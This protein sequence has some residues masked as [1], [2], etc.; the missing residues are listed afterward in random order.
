[1][2]NL[3]DSAGPMSTIF[4]L[5]TKSSQSQEYTFAA[6]GSWY[7]RWPLNTIGNSVSRT[8][9]VDPKGPHLNTPEAMKSP[10]AMH[11]VNGAGKMGLRSQQ[12]PN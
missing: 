9:P 4:V 3:L 2:A 8:V 7:T 6:R 5:V 11:K 1:M 12:S 10:T